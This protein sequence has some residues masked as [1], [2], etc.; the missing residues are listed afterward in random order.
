M[1]ALVRSDPGLTFVAVIT[2]VALVL[3]SRHGRTWWDRH[4]GRHHPARTGR[5]VMAGAALLGLGALTVGMALGGGPG[6]DP[7]AG[8][9]GVDSREAPGGLVFDG[10]VP[11]RPDAGPVTDTAGS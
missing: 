5:L 1:I 8:D 4:T 7:S 3:L 9:V 2:V 6:G 11:A 10:P